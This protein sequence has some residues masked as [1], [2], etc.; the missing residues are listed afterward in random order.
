MG[1]GRMRVAFDDRGVLVDGGD[2]Q[3]TVLHPAEP[4][5]AGDEAGL[6]LPE[7]AGGMGCWGG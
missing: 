4:G 3:G 2:V 6:D 1:K 7:G 5:D